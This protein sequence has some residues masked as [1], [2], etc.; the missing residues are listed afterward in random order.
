[1]HVIQTCVSGHNA[2]TVIFIVDMGNS[3]PT[4]VMLINP[5]TPVNSN[6]FLFHMRNINWFIA[7]SM[8]KFDVNS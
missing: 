8:D 1:M 3:N 7:Y 2:I 6:L 4:G 5:I